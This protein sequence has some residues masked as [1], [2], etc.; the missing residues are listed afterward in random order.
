[1]KGFRAYLYN[2]T[3]KTIKGMAQTLRQEVERLKERIQNG[4]RDV[5][6][7]ADREQLIEFSRSLDLL[8]RNTATTVT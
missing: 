7:E 3:I 4:E 6:D 1:M 2:P 8:K 5:N